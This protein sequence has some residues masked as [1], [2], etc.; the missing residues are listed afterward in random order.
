MIT[1][2]DVLQLEKFSAASKNSDADRAEE[3]SWDKEA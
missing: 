1:S 2:E 3:L